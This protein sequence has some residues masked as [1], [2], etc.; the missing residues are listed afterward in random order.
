[1]T[2]NILTRSKLVTREIKETMAYTTFGKNQVAVQVDSVVTGVDPIKKVTHAIMRKSVFDKTLALI[3][4]DKGDFSY[5]DLM[6]KADESFQWFFVTAA[7][8]KTFTEFPKDG[9]TT[10]NAYQFIC[11][12]QD[13][14]PQKDRTAHRKK[15]FTNAVNKAGQNLVHFTYDN[16][17]FRD[18]YGKLIP[19]PMHVDYGLRSSK[20]KLKEMVKHFRTLPQIHMA[21]KQ[22]HSWDRPY[23]EYPEITSVPHYNAEY[24]HETE[25][26]SAWIKLTQEQY[27]TVRGGK[28]HH[29]IAAYSLQNL[30]ILDLTEFK[31]PDRDG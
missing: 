29:M 22:K 31:K 4:K 26:S 7:Q 14:Q 24:D 3:A 15:L 1:M 20:Y 9:Q 2:T 13:D 28:E 6:H 16:H 11:D 23:A 21:A 18:I 5:S 25:I 10:N 8:R 17:T 12:V 27:E 19:V 30:G